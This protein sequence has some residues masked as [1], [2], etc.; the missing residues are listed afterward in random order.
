ME[1]FRGNFGFAVIKKWF[2]KPE[3]H[4]EHEAWVDP[5]RG[6]LLLLTDV[7]EDPVL[8]STRN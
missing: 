4:R 7:K 5:C 8:D 2:S 6:D 1:N 3:S